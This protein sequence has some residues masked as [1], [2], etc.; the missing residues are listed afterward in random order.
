MH[1]HVLLDGGNEFGDTAK[2]PAF[3]SLGAQIAKE[4]LDHVQLRRRGR[5][6]VHM[7]ARVLGEPRLN[8]GM[9]VRGVVVADQMH[10]F[11]LGRFPVDLAQVHEPLLMAVTL[12][13]T[14]NER[15]VQGAEGCEQGRGAVAFVV[16]SHRCSTALLQRQ[17]RLSAIKCLHLALFVAAQARFARSARNHP[18]T[19]EQKASNTEKSRVRVRVE[20]VFGAQEQMGGHIVRTIGL[21]R[22]QVKIGMMNLVYNMMRLGQL[23]RRDGRV[24]SAVA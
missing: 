1:G 22:A 2:D 9:L 24:A 4:A 5:G 23:L 17:A 19:A 18:L 8:I 12:L 3:Q 21:L 20:D 6:E 15:T 11:V 10:F 7:K 16:M 13:A 14:G